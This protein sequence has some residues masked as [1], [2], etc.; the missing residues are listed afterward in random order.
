MFVSIPLLS[1]GIASA[2][3]AASF[4]CNKATTASDKNICEAPTHLLPSLL[5]PYE[6][7]KQNLPQITGLGEAC[8]SY[9]FAFLNN[10]VVTWEL[11]EIHN[12]QCGGDPNTAPRIASLKTVKEPSGGKVS[13]AVDDIACGCWKWLVK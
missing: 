7:I 2:T 3:T 8:V 12:A 9:E 5:T 6:L 13:L 11:R 4:D 1:L 10:E